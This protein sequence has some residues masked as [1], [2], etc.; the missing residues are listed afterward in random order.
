MGLIARFLGLDVLA[1]GAILFVG[2]LSVLCCIGLGVALWWKSGQVDDLK[3][4]VK[5]AQMVAARCEA[6]AT[7][8]RGAIDS[9]NA[10]IEEMKA[11]A[12]RRAAEADRMILA[13]KNQART[14]YVRSEAIR[15]AK[16][17]VP[18]DLCQSADLLLN[19]FLKAR[20]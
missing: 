13:A 10:A 4:E 5:S 11:A 15:E 7:G 8:L 20:L 14:I 17:A 9:Q 19:D 6:E 3:A 2:A 18:T 12:I 16:P 1:Q